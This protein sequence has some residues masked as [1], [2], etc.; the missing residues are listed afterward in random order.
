MTAGVSFISLHYLCTFRGSPA[1]FWWGLVE[2]YFNSKRPPY[3]LTPFQKLYAFKTLLFRLMGPLVSLY[4]TAKHFPY[5]YSC[6][7]YKTP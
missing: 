2:G 3:A 6:H 4:Y 1:F 7:K 5:V